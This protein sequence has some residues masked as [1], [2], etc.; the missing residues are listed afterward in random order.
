[1]NTLRK[2]EGVNWNWR[3]G[4]GGSEQF[5]GFESRVKRREGGGYWCEVLNAVGTRD[6]SS[7]LICLFKTT[8]FHA[9]F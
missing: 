3:E 4:A 2:R 5:R 8:S 9:D 1:M 6:T 7:L